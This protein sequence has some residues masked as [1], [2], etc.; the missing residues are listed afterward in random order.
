ME[1]ILNPRTVNE[2]AV[3]LGQKLMQ[4]L[5]LS[6]NVTTVVHHDTTVVAAATLSDEL[7]IVP[8][9]ERL[10]Q[11]MLFNRVGD[12]AA[13]KVPLI[14]G[15]TI[16]SL[17]DR[18][19]QCATGHQGLLCQRCRDG[20]VHDFSG[21]GCRRCVKGEREATMACLIMVLFALMVGLF[22]LRRNHRLRATLT[23]MLAERNMPFKLLVGYIQVCSTIPENFRLVYPPPVMKLFRLMS[24]LDI[25]DIFGFVLNFECFFK[26]SYFGQLYMKVLGPLALLALFAVAYEVLR[27]REHSEN[28]A[29]AVFNTALLLSYSCYLSMVVTLFAYFDCRTFE[30]DQSYLVVAP[31]V[32]C[33]DEVYLRNRPIVMLLAAIV[34]LGFPC[35]YYHL[36]EKNAEKLN[37]HILG[38]AIDEFCDCLA[39]HNSNFFRKYGCRKHGVDVIG[40]PCKGS[41]GNILDCA[42]AGKLRRSTRYEVEIIDNQPYH[43]QSRFH[44]ASS[45]KTRLIQ[46]SRLAVVNNLAPSHNDEKDACAADIRAKNTAFLKRFGPAVAAYLLKKQIRDFKFKSQLRNT[47]FLWVRIQLALSPAS[48]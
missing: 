6:G 8:T 34:T 1:V 24:W 5:N 28:A 16:T 21:T 13:A 37:P 36:L 45:S 26:P 7:Q 9:A 20:F 39:T 40:G 44:G 14:H 15:F 25:M 48:Q 33:T 2:S 18:D 19:Q 11:I 32:K 4:A 22:Y 30:D 35:A 43:P 23:N 38:G 17:T 27:T 41:S 10:H 12:Q 3:V 29:A 47:S 31:A 42:F 46:G